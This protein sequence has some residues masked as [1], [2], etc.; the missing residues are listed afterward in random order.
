MK[1]LKFIIIAISCNVCACNAQSIKNVKDEEFNVLLNKFKTIRPPINYKKYFQPISDMT[2]EEAIRFFEKIEEDLYY[3]ELEYGFDTETVSYTKMENIPGTDFKYQ[4]NDSILILCTREAILGGKI[5]TILVI[6]YSFSV[7]GKI[8]DK[9][10]VGE[11]FTFSGDWVSFVLL[12]KH[13][14]RVFHYERDTT[15]EDEGYF[16]IVYYVEYQITDDGIFVE[17]HK[18]DPIYVTQLPRM[19]ETFNPSTKPDDPMNK[20]DF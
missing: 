16:T 3:V 7:D 8:I 14:I 5:D 18:S 10:I 12:D 2:K 15:R 17:K 1:T 13:T 20:Y 9:C 4:L 11:Q 19:Y 6:L